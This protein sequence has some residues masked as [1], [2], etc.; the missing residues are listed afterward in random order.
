[1]MRA[2]TQARHIVD[3]FGGP[4]AIAA[5]AG[6][7][8]AT[9]N[10]WLRSESGSIPWKQI[11]AVMVAAARSGVSIQDKDWLAHAHRQAYKLLA[12]DQ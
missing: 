10:G 11:P 12:Q 4:T 7:P 9:V 6:I 2:K 1:M 5:A 8:L 3:L